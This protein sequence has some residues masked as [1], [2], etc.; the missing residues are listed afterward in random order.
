[1]RSM[2]ELSDAILVTRLKELVAEER[3]VG[4]EVLAH[5]GEVEARR[6]FLPAACSSMHEYCVRALGFSEQ[7]AYK[8]IRV[9][10]LGRRFPEV[11]EAMAEGTLHLS[12]AMALAAH[13][14]EENVVE[15]LAEARGKR[16]E[17]IHVLVARLA[18]RPDVAPRVERVAVQGDLVAGA[19]HAVPTVDEW[20][21]VTPLAPERFEV[22]VT[23]SGEV[24]QKLARA[25][26][27]VRHQVPSGDIES[28]LE[29][30]LDA[31]IDKTE[32]RKFG[33]TSRPR[34]QSRTARA[35]HVPSEVRREVVARDGARCSFVSADGRRCEATAFLEMDHVTPVALG[36]DGSSAERVRVLCRSHN[37]YEAERVLGKDVVARGRARREIVRAKANPG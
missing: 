14:T 15:V 3:R 20:P 26:D 32:G 4:V 35:S 13:L 23:V 18:P 31:L 8:R 6:L 2:V 37:K 30:A 9:A 33:R 27:L 12:G 5:L 10:R 28:V 19:A 17:E 21:G 1:M 22:R 24:R 11:L 7:A 29:L 36:G 34:R 16:M 25:T